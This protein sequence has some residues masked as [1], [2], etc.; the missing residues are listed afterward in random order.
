MWN[1]LCGIRAV[2]R[3]CS[4]CSFR[5]CLSFSH[6]VIVQ[7]FHCRAMLGISVAY[8]VTRCPS[9]CLS[10]CLS[11]DEVFMTRSLNVMPKTTDQHLIVCSGKSEAEVTIIQDQRG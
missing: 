7:L 11:D 8:V 9:V 5:F 2:K 6:S 10:V 3:T 1:R 4:Y